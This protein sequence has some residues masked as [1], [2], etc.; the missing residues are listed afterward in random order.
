MSQCNPL[1]HLRI[2]ATEMTCKEHAIC[3]CL[4]HIKS[5]TVVPFCSLTQGNLLQEIQVTGKK[6]IPKSIVQDEGHAMLAE[7][8][9]RLLPAHAEGLVSSSVLHA[10]CSVQRAEASVCLCVLA[11]VILWHWL[12]H[13][14]CYICS[15]LAPSV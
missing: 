12:G 4:L 7:V 14:R 13:C 15:T 5:H 6:L 1:T 2:H 8:H 3:P 10:C 9:V 11:R